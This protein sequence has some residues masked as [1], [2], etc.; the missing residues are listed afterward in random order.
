ME[1]TIRILKNCSPL[2][3]LKYETRYPSDKFFKGDKAVNL[4]SIFNALKISTNAVGSTYIDELLNSISDCSIS[5]TDVYACTIL[6]NDTIIIYYIDSNGQGSKRLYL[7]EELVY[8]CHNTDE[9][10]TEKSHC[11]IQ[12]VDTEIYKR[13]LELL[14]PE[15]RLIACVKFLPAP[16]LDVLSEMFC[17]NMNDMEER[18]LDLRIPYYKP[19]TYSSR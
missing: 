18:L 9:L 8:L 1:E 19:I 17:V 11:L 12:P 4:E 16:L 5:S 13:A 14:I 6:N 10:T 3:L 2:D 15:E 7:A